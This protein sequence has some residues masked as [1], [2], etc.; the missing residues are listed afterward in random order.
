MLRKVW[1]TRYLELNRYPLLAVTPIQG[2][3]FTVH[4]CTV[5]FNKTTE[6]TASKT[7]LRLFN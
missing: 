4:A 7:S 6:R 5:N 3:L 1:P 2:Q